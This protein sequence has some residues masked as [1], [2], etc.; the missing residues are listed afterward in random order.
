MK[1]RKISR[2]R[3]IE[4]ATMLGAAIPFSSLPFFGRNKRDS[5]SPPA[6]SAS[7]V[8]WY[9]KPATQWVE[10]LPIGNGRFG[11][12]IFGGT[13]NER[14][15]L[16]EDTLYAGGPYDPDNPEALDAIPEA[17]RLIFE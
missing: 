6:E 15:Q 2:R 7:L 17:R 10:A 16:N 3:F 11:A 5:N 4:R 12:M 14:L 13:E 9:D 1:K 8:L